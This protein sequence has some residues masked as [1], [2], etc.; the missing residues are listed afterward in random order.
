MRCAP[1]FLV[2]VLL[3]FS[4]R[5]FGCVLSIQNGVLPSSGRIAAISL[6]VTRA[7]IESGPRSSG[8]RIAIDNDPSWRTHL[9][10]VAVVGAAF[11]DPGSLDGLVSLEP[12]PG[13]TCQFLDR[14]GELTLRLKVYNDDAMHAFVLRRPEMRVG[15]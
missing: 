2:G 3:V 11:V 5:A 4:V 6:D 10:A 8:W 1:A 13:V 14:H 9:K 15:D 12:E 7:L